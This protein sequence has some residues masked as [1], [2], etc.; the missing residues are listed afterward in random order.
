MAAVY[1]ALAEVASDS[2]LKRRLQ[3]LA[4]TEWRHADAWAALLD[5]AVDTTRTRNTNF[6]ARFLAVLARVAFPVGSHGSRIGAGHRPRR[7]GHPTMVRM[8]GR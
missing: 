4:E 8:G 5:G 1:A 2:R 7:R 3:A 6:T